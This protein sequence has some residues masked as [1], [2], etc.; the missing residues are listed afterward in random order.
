MYAKGGKGAKWEIVRYYPS[1]LKPV[2]CKGLMKNEFDN[3]I[4][5]NSLSGISYIAINDNGLWGLIKMEY[6]KIKL[7]EKMNYSN[8]IELQN[9]YGISEL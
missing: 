1:G 9:K 8:L 5:F 7:V 2:K 4:P 3:I 6:G